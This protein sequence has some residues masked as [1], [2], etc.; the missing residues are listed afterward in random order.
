MLK[1]KPKCTQSPSPSIAMS[2]GIKSKGEKSWA[3]VPFVTIERA[4]AP[5]AMTESYLLREG[6]S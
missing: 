2:L 3:F 5:F 6:K 1:E 4:F